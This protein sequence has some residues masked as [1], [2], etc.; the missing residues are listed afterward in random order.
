MSKGVADAA[1][2]AMTRRIDTHSHVPPDYASRLHAKGLSAGGLPIP[3]WDLDSALEV[4][5][6]HGDRRCG[7]RPTYGTA[8]ASPRDDRHRS[9]PEVPGGGT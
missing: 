5:D 4:M 3:R 7:A 2:E 8:L 9:R 6:R 1:G